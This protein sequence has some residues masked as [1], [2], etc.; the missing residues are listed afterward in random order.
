L[1]GVGTLDLSGRSLSNAGAIRPGLSTGRLSVTGTLTQTETALL[2]IEIGGHAPGTEFDQLHVSDEAIL[3]GTLDLRLVDGFV[4]EIG[5]RF[6]I[7][8]CGHRSG[9]FA[10]V[11][12]QIDAGRRFQVI[13][14]PDRVDLLVVEDYP[15]YFPVVFR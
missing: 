15:L 2:S 6:T 11:Y 9:M 12:G 3:G 8:T 5:D 4:P 10:R 7:L 1:T 13:Y 14:H